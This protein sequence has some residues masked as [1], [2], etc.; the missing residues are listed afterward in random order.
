L[1]EFAVLVH[2]LIYVPDDDLVQVETCR[3]DV[4][5]KLL[6]LLFIID[7]VICWIEYCTAPQKLNHSVLNCEVFVSGDS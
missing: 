7:C 1:T 4:S 2:L 6:L 3:R 5:G